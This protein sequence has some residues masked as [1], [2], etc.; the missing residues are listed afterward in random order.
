MY[1]GDSTNPAAPFCCQALNRQLDPDDIAAAQYIYGVC[2]DFNRDG[3]VDATDYV[4]WRNTNGQSVTRGTGA[5]GNVDGVVNPLDYNEWRSNFGNIQI[6]GFGEQ[7]SFGAGANVPEPSALAI[8]LV[9]SVGAA[10]RFR[11]GKGK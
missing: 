8:M 1:V 6:Q 9:A 7:P 11:R 4:L 3:R 5:D 10:I 2:G